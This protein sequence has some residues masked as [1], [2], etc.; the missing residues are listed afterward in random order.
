MPHSFS[1]IAGGVAH[2]PELF[3]LVGMWIVVC[4]IISRMGW[5]RFATAYPSHYRPPGR[6]YSVPV[7][8]FGKAGALYRSSV[9]AVVTE[10][11]LYLYAFWLVRAFHKPFTLPWSSIERVE[12][13]ASLWKPGYILHIRDGVGSFQMHVGHE[14]AK[15]LIRYVPHHFPPNQPATPM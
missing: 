14:L 7:V 2:L 4:F 13:C 11:G 3:S 15:E 1:V 6:V 8:T 10:V 12:L 5:I 9:R